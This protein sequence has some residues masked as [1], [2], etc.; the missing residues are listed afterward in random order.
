MCIATAHAGE[1]C[2]QHSYNVA[3]ALIPAKIVLYKMKAKIVANSH[4]AEI[5]LVYFRP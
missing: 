4:F 5:L 2:G 1:L 3:L